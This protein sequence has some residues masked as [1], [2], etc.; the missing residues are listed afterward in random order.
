MADLYSELRDRTASGSHLAVRAQHLDAPEGGAA[1]AD[2][3]EA[4]L[5]APVKGDPLVEAAFE[6]MKL[7]DREGEITID[8]VPPNGSCKV[9][10]GT[11]ETLDAFVGTDRCLLTDERH[12]GRPG[13]GRGMPW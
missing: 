10:L 7:V 13:R 11:P 5:E 12:E 1:T 6:L 8:S 2:E 9:A 3:S 4:K